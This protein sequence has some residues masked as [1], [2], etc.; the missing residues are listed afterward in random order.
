V[1]I[2]RS[3]LSP[4]TPIYKNPSGNIYQHVSSN[5]HHDNPLHEMSAIRAFSAIRF[6]NFPM[7]LCDRNSFHHF[8]IS[9]FSSNSGWL[10]PAKIDAGQTTGPEWGVLKLSSP[11]G[12]G[13]DDCSRIGCTHFLQPHF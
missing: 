2:F 12:P 9:A 5:A 1:K 11:E 6:N 8:T 7:P 4:K 10:G 3:N 13:M